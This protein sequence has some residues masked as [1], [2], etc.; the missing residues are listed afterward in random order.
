MRRI[1]HERPLD[2][3]SR[4]WVRV[5]ITTDRGEVMDFTVQYETMLGGERTPV[6]RYDFAHGFAHLDLLDHR[7]VLV[8]KRPLPGNPSAKEALA[9][10]LQDLVN[11]WRRYRTAFRRGRP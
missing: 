7:G 6:A 11:N 2:D 4:E 1:E 8:V 5:R 3:E 9:L 10:G